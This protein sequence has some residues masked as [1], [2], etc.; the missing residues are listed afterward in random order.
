MESDKQGIHNTNIIKVIINNVSITQS[1]IKEIKIHPTR[2]LKEF[3]EFGLNKEFYVLEDTNFSNLSIAL[4]EMLDPLVMKQ[5]VEG[6]LARIRTN[7]NPFTPNPVYKPGEHDGEKGDD[8]REKPDV[9]NGIHERILDN[10]IKYITDKI[11]HSNPVPFDNREYKISNKSYIIKSTV[12][13]PDT[14]YKDVNV[15]VYID[16][17]PFS[18]ILVVD[19]LK[20]GCFQGKTGTVT[21]IISR[22]NRHIN[23]GDNTRMRYRRPI[24][25][26]KRYGGMMKGKTRKNRTRKN[27]TRKNRTRKNRTRKNRTRKNMIMMVSKKHDA[28]K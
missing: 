28:H 8:L 7:N 6:E 22:N 15:A 20:K 16:I 12:I 13:N 5:A 11:F 3:K 10:N 9:I 4:G 25:G 23:I 2:I 1:A 21:D 14:N 17:I 27:R 24:L 26:K 18:G 19:L